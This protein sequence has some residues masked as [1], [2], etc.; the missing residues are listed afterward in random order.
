MAKPKIYQSKTDHSLWRV[1][2]RRY[3]YHH[4]AGADLT[5]TKLRASDG[6]EITL[7]STD[8]DEWNDLRPI[9]YE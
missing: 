4:G 6:T 5:T 1:I 8:D 3:G 7:A 2:C 9:S